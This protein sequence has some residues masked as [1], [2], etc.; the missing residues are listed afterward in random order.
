MKSAQIII[1]GVG[2][3]PWDLLTLEAKEILVNAE[4]VFFRYATHP[5]FIKLKEMGKDVIPF[6]LLYADPRLS[7]RK[8]YELMSLSIVREAEIKGKAVYAL[9]G[10]PFVFEKTPRM[11]GELAAQKGYEIKF[12]PGMSF[13]EQLYCYL[14]IDPEEGLLVLNASRMVERPEDYIP[15]PRLACVIGQVGLPA[16]TKPTERN[17]NTDKLG[18][19]LTKFYPPDHPAVVVRCVGIP[20]YELEKKEITVGTVSKQHDFVNNLTSLYIPPV[21]EERR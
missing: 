16:G 12:V 6:E 17:F 14:H 9:P 5:V 18:G 3:G 4:R 13:L 8:A 10:N 19:I 7:Y 20:T 21:K 15:N 1:V 2:P 11:I